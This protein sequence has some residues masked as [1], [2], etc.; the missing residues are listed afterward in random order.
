[1][2]APQVGGRRKRVSGKYKTRVEN[3]RDDKM[4]ETTGIFFTGSLS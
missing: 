2:V 3:I 4:L 1:M